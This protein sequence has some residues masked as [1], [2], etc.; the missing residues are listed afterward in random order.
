MRTQLAERFVSRE[1]TRGIRGALHENAARGAHV[2]RMKIVPI[3]DLGAIGIAEF[4][5]KCLLPGERLVVGHIER[6]VMRGARAESPT[7]RWTSRLMQQDQS[8]S[9]ATGANLESMIRAVHAGLAEAQCFHEKAFLFFHL[10]H[11]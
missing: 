11:R 8:L 7:A 4:F 1:P 9:R 10:S 2:N 3:L 5:V 6:D